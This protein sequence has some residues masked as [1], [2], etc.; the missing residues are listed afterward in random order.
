ML[1]DHYHGAEQTLKGFV[2]KPPS[3]D[4]LVMQKDLGDATLLYWVLFE[5]LMC[6][7]LEGIPTTE[8]Y[9]QIHVTLQ[10]QVKN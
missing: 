3:F 4:I 7:A 1:C 2:V 9:L 6:R 10:L 5:D 8:D